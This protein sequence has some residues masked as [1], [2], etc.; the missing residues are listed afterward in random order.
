[1]HKKCTCPSLYLF[2][3][4]NNKNKQNK[5]QVQFVIKLILLKYSLFL[6]NF[7][8]DFIKSV[9]LEV[10]LKL[11]STGNDKTRKKMEKDED[12]HL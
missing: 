12:S 2:L 10:F 6:F 11:S 9:I 5:K 7:L 3:F 1:M 8:G 4:L